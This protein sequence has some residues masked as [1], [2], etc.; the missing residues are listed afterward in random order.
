M[1]VIDLNSPR[2][3]ALSSASMG[4]LISGQKFGR[5]D[6]ERNR[7][8]ALARAAQSGVTFAVTDADI[9]LM[10]KHGYEV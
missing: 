2:R 9:E 6:Q 8:N 10:R 5:Y 1:K 7:A 4:S 3:C